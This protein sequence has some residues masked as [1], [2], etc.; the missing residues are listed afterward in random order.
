M[1]KTLLVTVMHSEEY[2]L[3]DDK[4]HI[5]ITLVLKVHNNDINSFIIITAESEYGMHIINIYFII[6]Y[7][8]NLILL[9]M[10][11]NILSPFSQTLNEQNGHHGH[12]K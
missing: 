11:D 7:C 6:F 8:L 1:F 2:F 3:Q 9:E 5:Y 12:K 4:H 10:C